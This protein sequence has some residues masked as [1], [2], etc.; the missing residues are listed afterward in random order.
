MR[1]RSARC[2]ALIL[3]AALAACDTQPTTTGY[4]GG[5]YAIVRL[6]NVSTASLDLVTGSSVATG[7]GGLAFGASSS[8]TTVDVT[9]P[10]LTVRTTGTT[11]PLSGFSPTFASGNK[12]I[13]V[14]YT[15]ANGLTQ[16]TVGNTNAFAP[17]SVQSGLKVVDAVPGT[18]SFDVYVTP[19]GAVLGTASATALSFAGSTNFFNVDAAATQ[20]RLTNAGTQT[21]VFTTATPTSTAGRN[22]VLII[23][24]PAT[25]TSEFRSF[26]VTSC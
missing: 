9:A 14:A 2:C 5:T 25:G 15:N 3:T 16:F 6:V 13:V 20:V 17:G 12:Y 26:L 24:P 1:V 19:P 21:V 22:Y 4:A 11:T 23:G 10:N 18:S 7:N 8:C